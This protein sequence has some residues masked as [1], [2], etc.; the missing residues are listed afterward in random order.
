M[1]RHTSGQP[2]VSQQ[3][4]GS[5]R[6][7]RICGG[8][9]R[10]THRGIILAKYAV[11]YHLCTTCEYWYTDEPFWLEEAYGQAIA[12]T[13][14]GLVQRNI[15][16]ARALRAVLPLLFPTGP[17]VDWAGGHG[18]LVRLLRDSGL[19][20]YWQDRYAENL[21]ARGF[22]WEANRNGRDATVVTAVEV[23]EH[24]PDPLGLLHECM[25]G[26]GAE[27]VIFTQVLHA[28]GDDPNWWYLAP[29]TGQHVSFFSAKTLDWIGDELGMHLQSAGGLHVLTRSPIRASR[30]RWAIRVSRLPSRLWDRRRAASLTLVDH[31]K[32][33]ERL[34]AAQKDT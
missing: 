24:S 21:L 30:L 17:Y 26:S 9:T 16:V 25:A 23:L 6:P 8:P 31:M 11:T 2:E 1:S 7:C 33:T 12:A 20:F 27:T 28:G 15:G 32:M 29:V 5:G 22:D 3:Q 14:T 10:V 34:T 19:E 4:P 18:M 13:D